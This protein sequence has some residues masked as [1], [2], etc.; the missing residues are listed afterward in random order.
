MHRIRMGLWRCGSSSGSHLS[1]RS[2]YTQLPN[3]AGTVGLEPT[4]AGIKIPCL[5]NLAT[6]QHSAAAPAPLKSAAILADTNPS[7][8]GLRRAP[9][10]HHRRQR[11][12]VHPAR[13]VRAKRGWAGA[14]DVRRRH[15]RVRR[16]EYATA[17]AGQAR[18][19]EAREPIQRCRDRRK[20]RPHY[21]RER[22]VRRGAC[23]KARY[24]QPRRVSCQ[25]RRL[26]HGRRRQQRGR[27][28]R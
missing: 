14:H 19:A 23:K 18:I 11:R 3:V 20:L 8:R 28:L 6:S 2:T 24:C 10:C 5:T 4:N 22:V 1:Q 15:C 25:F 16:D 27:D 12:T 21:R 13:R 7:G 9:S 17:A 26:K